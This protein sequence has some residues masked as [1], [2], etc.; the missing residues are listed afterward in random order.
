MLQ[1][2]KNKFYF[3]NS[4][5][6]GDDFVQITKPPD[7]YEIESLNKEIKRI[8][9]EEEHFTESNCP[10]Q[11][12]PNFSTPGS[13]I[14]K[15]PQTQIISFVFDDSIRSLPGFNETILYKEDNL[16]PNPVDISSFDS[17]FFGM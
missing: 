4:I 10:F 14:E 9:F 12:K 6:D 11:I 5:T 3:K 1:K 15:S 16:S 7:A 13:V 17:V 2:S 8:N